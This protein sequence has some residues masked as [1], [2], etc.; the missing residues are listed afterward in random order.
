MTTLTIGNIEPDIKARL[1]QAAAAHGRSMKKEVRV[2]LC[3]VLAQPA[4]T[5][6]LGSRIRSRFAP[7]DRL[8]LSLPERS[9]SARAATFEDGPAP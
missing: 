9:A 7:E 5:S 4:A 3:R 6:G 8:D 2:I 1:R